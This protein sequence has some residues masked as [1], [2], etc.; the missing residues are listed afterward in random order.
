MRFFSFSCFC[1]ASALG[2]HCYF[3]WVAI[4]AAAPP[5]PTTTIATHLANWEL[6]KILGTLLCYYYYIIKDR[7]A[8]FALFGNSMVVFWLCSLRVYTRSPEK[9]YK[10][11]AFTITKVSFN[12]FE[13]IQLTTHT[14]TYRGSRYSETEQNIR[15]V[16]SP[17]AK[18]LVLNKG[19]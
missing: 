8:S 3:H 14:S 15:S 6:Y 5:S 9:E 12:C 13:E 1:D 7:R 19:K 10:D 4:V 18:R 11:M 2:C 17:N 16:K